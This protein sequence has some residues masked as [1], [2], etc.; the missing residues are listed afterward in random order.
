[1]ESLVLPHPL[2]RNPLLLVPSAAQCQELKPGDLALNCFGQLE[3]V[4][5]VYARGTDV[6]GS[7]YVCFYAAFG[8]SGATISGSYRAGEPVAT[9]PL[10]SVVHRL[11]S[12]N[13]QPLALGTLYRLLPSTQGLGAVEVAADGSYPDSAAILSLATTH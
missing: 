2:T 3:P 9:V 13:I 1:M 4:S 10:T 7:A 6:H 8:D 11:D 5:E 12:L